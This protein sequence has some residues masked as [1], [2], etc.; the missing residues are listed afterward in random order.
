MIIL[1]RL[2]QLEKLPPPMLMTLSGIATLVRLLQPE[3]AL[4]SML[5]TDDTVHSCSRFDLDPASE[6][7]PRA[8]VGDPLDELSGRAGRAATFDSHNRS[9]AAIPR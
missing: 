6:S 7:A 5:M 3:K 2:L 4:V 9:I 1:S 8:K